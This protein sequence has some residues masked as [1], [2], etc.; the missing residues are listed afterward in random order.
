MQHLSKYQQFEAKKFR[1]NP[2]YKIVEKISIPEAIDRIKKGLIKSDRFKHVMRL[3]DTCVKCGLKSDHVMLGRDKGG[4]LH[5]DLYAKDDTMMTID[6]IL[7]RSKGGVD[8]HKNYQ[9]MC[10]PCNESKGNM[11]E[12]VDELIDAIQKK[13]MQD[14]ACD[15]WLEFVHQQELGNC[16]GICSAIKRNFPMVDHWFGEIDLDEPIVDE[17]GDE[18]FKMTHHWIEIN[19]TI[20]EFSKGTLIGY[21]EM[22]EYDLENVESLGDDRYHKK[23]TPN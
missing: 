14:D 7:P 10:M 8:K 18:H 20:Y 17:E 2:G 16:Q 3:G 13:L 19:K 4:S 23:H 9:L 5:W 11:I 22:D 15:T 6:H 21:I 1:I 12:N